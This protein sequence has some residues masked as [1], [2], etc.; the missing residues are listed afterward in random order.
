MGAGASPRRAINIHPGGMVDV[1]A[2]GSPVMRF[3]DESA[4]IRV[5][6]A[7]RRVISGSIA[8]GRM[9]LI[10]HRA[11]RHRDDDIEHLA[12]LH[13]G[14]VFVKDAPLIA[15][16]PDTNRMVIVEH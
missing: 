2:I 11:Y 14:H 7:E 6:V 16:V 12:L 4:V 1:R 9:L 15:V 8:G 3:P 10:A 13:G 5:A